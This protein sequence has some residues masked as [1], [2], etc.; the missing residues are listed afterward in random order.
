MLIGRGRKEGRKEAGSKEEERLEEQN[1]RR[2]D[3]TRSPLASLGMSG[4]QR[5]RQRRPSCQ[6]DLE[7]VIQSELDLQIELAVRSLGP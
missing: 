7:L 2:P 5:Q 3:S 1:G 6:M 4:R